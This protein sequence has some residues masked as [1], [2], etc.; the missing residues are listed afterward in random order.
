MPEP[1][2]ESLTY[3]DGEAELIGYLVADRSALRPGVLLVHD[4]TGVSEP[5][6]ATARRIAGLGYAVLLVDLWGE[7]GHRV[8]RR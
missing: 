8:R 2:A 7:G 5:M 6:K 4:A 3:R 1:T